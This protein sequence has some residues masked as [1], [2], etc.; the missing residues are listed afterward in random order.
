MGGDE[1]R[2]A[3]N[4]GDVAMKLGELDVGLTMISLRLLICRTKVP[5]RKNS[6][7]GCAVNAMIG[8]DTKVSGLT[9]WFLATARNSVLAISTLDELLVEVA[10][11]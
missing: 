5:I 3:F 7:D 11:N 6:R 10:K 1:Q 2:V 4:K 8:K 9:S